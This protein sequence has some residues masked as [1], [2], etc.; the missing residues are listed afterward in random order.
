MVPWELA[1][2][3][4]AAYRDRIHVA[5]VIV[6][7]FYGRLHRQG[8]WCEGKCNDFVLQL[9]GTDFMVQGEL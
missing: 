2:I 7:G 1:Q 8:L 5:R 4:M 3:C 6:T 9:T